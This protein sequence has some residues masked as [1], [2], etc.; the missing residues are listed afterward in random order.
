MSVLVT[1][2][3]GYIGSH[4]VRLLVASGQRVVI[5]DDLSSGVESRING[6]PLVNIDLSTE[7]AEEQLVATMKCHSVESVIHFAAKKQVG[8]SVEQPVWYYKQNVGGLSNLLSAMDAA[9]VRTMVFSSS[10]AVYGMPDTEL[11]NE[12]TPCVPIN[13]YG[14]TKLIGE[15]M[16]DDAAIAFELKSVKLRYFNVAGAGWPDLRD[17]AV[18]NLIPIVLERVRA[19]RPPVIFGDDYPTPDGTCIRDYVHVMD[20]AE[21]H[22]SALDFLAGDTPMTSVFNVGTGEGASVRE[23]IETV[24]NETGEAITPTIGGRRA[25]DPPSLVA[26]VENIAAQL[27]WKSERRLADIVKSAL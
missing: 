27:S 26:N 15:W 9:D 21:A 14:K 3:A 24:S 25:G 19:G 8:E 20:L 17:T 11:V 2:G 5:V 22:I 6:V 7:G 23:I 16:I 18:M 1:G 12:S 10:A 13:P 4:V